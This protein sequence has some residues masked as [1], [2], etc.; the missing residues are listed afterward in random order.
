MDIMIA[1]RD[2]LQRSDYSVTTIAAH[3]GLSRATLSDIMDG[4]NIN[5]RLD[6]IQSLLDEVGLHITV[7]TDEQ[8]AMLPHDVDWYRDQIA[9]RDDTI[10]RLRQEIAQ[11]DVEKQHAADTIQELNRRI[12]LREELIQQTAERDNEMVIG[13]VELMKKIAK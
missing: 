6:T 5:P 11:R 8:D 12:K 7:V 1:L 13:L 10:R 4:R 9:Q 3:T 2:M